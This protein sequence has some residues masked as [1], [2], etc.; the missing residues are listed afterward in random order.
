MLDMM[1]KNDFTNL[2]KRSTNCRNLCEHFITVAVFIPEPFQTACM[3]SDACQAFG[4][5]L[6]S[7]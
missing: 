7:D 4:N 1:L 2:I 5:V 3:T 6:T